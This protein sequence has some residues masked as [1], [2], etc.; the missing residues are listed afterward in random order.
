MKRLILALFFFAL[1][2]CAPHTP[3]QTG[4]TPAPVRVLG[5][6]DETELVTLKGNIHPLARAPFDRGA[7]PGSMPTNRI[8]LVLRRSSEQQRELTQYLSDLQNP[9]S[10][11]YHKWLTPEQFGTAFGVSQLDLLQVQSWLQSHGFEIEKIPAARNVIEFSG[12]FDQVQSAFHTSIHTF[13]V[14]GETHLAN[15]NDPQIPAALAPVIAG[16]GPLNDF[17]AKPMLVR[18]P[19]GRFDPS[20]G[21]IVPELTLSSNNTLYLFVDPADAA[22]IYDTPN[23]LL[24]PAY[25]GTTY[26]GTGV[27]IG[28][29]GVSDLFTADVANY[30]MAFLG[31]ASGSVNLPTVVVDGNDPGLTG[32]G[33]EALLDTE[34]A[35]GIAPKART[36]FYTSADTDLSSGLLNAIF[37]ALDDNTVSILSVSFSSCEAALGT[38][39]NQVILEAAE[40]AA[41]QGITLTVSAGDNGSAGCDDFDTEAHAT[42]SFAVNGFAST[43]YTIAVG[44]TDFDVLSTAFASYVNN[45]TSGAPPYYATALKYIPEKPWN[46]STSVNTTYSNNVAQKNSNGEGNIVAGSG[47]ISTVYA[48]PAF[49]SSLT[50]NDGARDLPD[51]S[52]LAGNG[53]YSA[54]WVLCSDN[55]TD[56]VTSQA[57]TECLTTGGQFTSNT[58]FGGVG[59]TS[60]SAPAFAGMLALVAQAHGSASDNYR[61]GQADNI[62]YQ[63]AQSKYSTI[64]HDITTGNNSVACA[65]GSPHCG[66]NLFLTGYNAGTGYDLA[67]GLGSVN[68]AAMVTNWTSVPLASTST[69]LNINGFTTAYSG[70]HGQSLTF[71]VSVSPATATGVAGIVDNVGETAGGTASGPQNH[72]Q[73][74]VPLISGSGSISYNGLPG[75]SYT[76]WARYGG[77]TA[78]ASSTSTPPIS[79]SISAE[80]STTTL[81]VNAYDP[82]TGNA[83]ST[84][85]TP[86]GSYVFADAAI[87]GTAEGSKTQGVASGTVQFL[88]GGTALGSSAVSSG[89]EASWPPLNST[90]VPGGSYNLT[91]KYSGDASYDPSTSS[92]VAFTVVP[93]ATKV[94]P[95]V[96]Q[97]ILGSSDSTGVEFYLQA[98]PNFGVS[99]TGA[100]TVAANGSTLDTF[101]L[102]MAG[103]FS[104]YLDATIQASQLVSG[105]NTVTA[106]YSGDSNYATS[107]TSFSMYVTSGGVTIGPIANMSVSPGNTAYAPVTLAPT[108]GFIGS[109]NTSCTVASAANNS[110]TC[111]A[112]PDYYL[113]GAGP[114]SGMITAAATSSASAGSYNATLTVSNGS[115]TKVL[116]TASFTIT[117]AAAAAA[118]SFA[119]FSNGN[120]D[121]GPGATSGNTSSVT[122]IPSGGL[123]GQLN[124]TCAVTTTMANPVAPPACSVPASVTITTAQAVIVPVSVTSSTTTTTGEYTFSVTATAASSSSVTGSSTAALIVTSSPAFALASASSVSYP[125]GATTGNTTTV[126]ATPFNGYGGTVNLACTEVALTTVSG[127]AS[128]YPECMVPSSIFVGGATPTSFT[129]TASATGNPYPVPGIYLFTLTGYDSVSASLTSQTAIQLTFGAPNAALALSNNGNITVAPGATTGNTS[130]ITITPSGGF[131][132]AVNLSCQVSTSMS[133]YSDLPT[134]SIPASATIS[135]TTAATALLTVYTTAATSGALVPGP[136]YLRFGGLTTVLAV[137]FFLGVSS[138]R[139]KWM[140]V[141]GAI[142]VALSIG[143]LGC[144]G[145]GGTGAGGGGSGGNSGTTAGAYSVTVTGTDEATGK[146]TAQTTVALSV[147]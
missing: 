58:Y 59:G 38:S 85:N 137:V 34:V 117:V 123:T 141:V 121:I 87:T 94:T 19:N 113:G 135:G 2:T 10:P 105:A 89:N 111:A 20:T 116:S 17:H 101:S 16:V 48:K 54:T 93:E 142:V 102:F 132:G 133:S 70:V 23:S 18:G 92:S 81:T 53:M 144:G 138:K 9:A 44:G 122:I 39:G 35:G 128:T 74:A 119:I 124:L 139:R 4:L 47:G 83:I 3:A 62:L 14:N 63:L 46:D 72:G 67:S 21:R 82:L 49:Q 103:D 77:D 84:S 79:V 95:Y 50:P 100:V 24:N 29:A 71:G 52:L 80:P 51:V 88:N 147:N 57:Y 25:S 104:E 86:Y 130:R 134:C 78:N 112:Q 37:R 32:A 126:T 13:I 140:R 146:I 120:L 96:H 110:V 143:A 125:P 98:A 129:L 127:S 76:V 118:P 28:I 68:A 36:Y 41:A 12:T 90:A 1:G 115:L 8:R 99:P 73:I 60:A 5:S 108:G 7:A 42:G 145:G 106:T 66:S 30:R 15:L 55:V 109:V 43:P 64:F 114:I 75:G 40:Q 61:L 97:Y 56:G 33:T 27:V 11:A 91:A 136:G 107:S 6:I 69:S 31:E 26:D 131:T 22:I 65:S 45:T